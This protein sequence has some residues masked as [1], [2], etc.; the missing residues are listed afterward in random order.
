MKAE[1]P[2]SR[3]N[4]C[5][6]GNTGGKTVSHSANSVSRGP[7]VVEAGQGLYADVYCSLL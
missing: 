7:I 5:Y 6:K 2:V 4:F 3:G 1:M